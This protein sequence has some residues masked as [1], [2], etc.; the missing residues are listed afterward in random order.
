MGLLLALIFIGALVWWFRDAKASLA[1]LSPRTKAL[2]IAGMFVLGA[3]AL[4]LLRPVFRGGMFVGAAI[5]TVVAIA[6]VV[7]WQLLA[8]RSLPD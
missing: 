6:I 3:G 7:I 8:R 4:V 1:S 2:R 5:A